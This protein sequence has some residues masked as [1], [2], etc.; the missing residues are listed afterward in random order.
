MVDIFSLRPSAVMLMP[1][2]PTTQNALVVLHMKISFVHRADRRS[3]TGTWH[4][5]PA[6]KFRSFALI[7]AFGYKR[8]IP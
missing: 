7:G 2:L 4:Q 6:G 1:N 3:S 5:V 8:Q